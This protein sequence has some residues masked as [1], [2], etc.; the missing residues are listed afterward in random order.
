MA[1]QQAPAG[2]SQPA[3]PAS[4]ATE[5]TELTDLINSLLHELTVGF[6]AHNA[7]MTRLSKLSNPSR[8]RVSLIAN[9]SSPV[10]RMEERLD[11]L[12]NNL[13]ALQN[14][15]QQKS[16]QPGDAGHSS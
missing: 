2:A 8:N 3:V 11:R 16:G 14:E 12:E 4:P 5:A 15:K 6:D 10:D 7:E 13:I 9:T 1:N